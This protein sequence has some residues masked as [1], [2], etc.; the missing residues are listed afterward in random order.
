MQVL[1]M[2][3]NETQYL[4]EILANFVEIEG[5]TVLDVKRFIDK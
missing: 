3:L 5:E 1:F 4:N 2:V